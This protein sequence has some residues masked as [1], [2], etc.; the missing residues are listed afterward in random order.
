[1]TGP[2]NEEITELW[3]R[4]QATMRRKMIEAIETPLFKD[5]VSPFDGVDYE[6]GGCC[7][8]SGPCCVFL[9]G[10]GVS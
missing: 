10:D 2:T 1:M 8:V 6:S 9:A 3:N 4:Y 7:I 5:Y